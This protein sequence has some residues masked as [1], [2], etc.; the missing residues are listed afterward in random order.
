MPE[1]MTRAALEGRIRQLENAAAEAASLREALRQAEAKYRLLVE[2]ANDAIFILQDAKVKYA[3]P[4]ALAMASTVTEELQQAHYTQFLHPEDRAMVVER[5]E[6]RLQGEK[7]LNMYPL[8]IVN[9]R[10]E[11]IWTEVN[12]VVI[13]WEQ[14]PATLN[15]IRDISAQKLAEKQLLQAEG[16]STLRTMAGGL[17]HS[18]NNLLMGIQGR[19]SL[20]QKHRQQ[21]SEFFHLL[22]GI[23]QCVNEAA[24]LTRQM[25]GFAQ[26]G[27]YQVVRLSLN[28]VVEDIAR[29]VMLNTKSIE[30]NLRLA[31]DLWL[32][33][34][35]R[36][37]IEQ[38]VMNIVLNARQAMFECGSVT[39]STENIEW[40]EGR[41][42]FHQLPAGRYVKLTVRDTGA[43]MD[44]MVRKRAFEPFFTTKGVGEH[45]GLGLSR[46]YG[47]I[48]NHNGW[49]DIDSMPQAGTT[50]SVYLPAR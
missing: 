31:P 13:E 6:K 27:K 23:E 21:D 2:H 47:I 40:E 25:L 1:E 11:T 42:R 5:H 35:D 32:I 26:T 20:L 18:F 29:S 39:V 36:N 22:E 14:R 28:T 45:R 7:I 50:V 44:D 48:S 37:Q 12:V 3:N 19:S 34:A 4:K 24:G 16:I 10:G 43:G 46:V 30:L 9:N 33:E 17:A 8:R 41:G 15:I 49:V 38:A